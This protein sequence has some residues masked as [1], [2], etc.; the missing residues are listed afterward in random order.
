MRKSFKL[1]MVNR[2]SIKVIDLNNKVSKTTKDRPSLM[3]IKLFF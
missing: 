2:K 1:A 3:V